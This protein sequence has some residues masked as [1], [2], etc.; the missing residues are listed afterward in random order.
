MSTK[1]SP[2][3]QRFQKNSVEGFMYFGQPAYNAAKDIYK[4]HYSA[5]NS[6]F[7]CSRTPPK[8][9]RHVSILLQN[10]CF[11][12]KNMVWRI[13]WVDYIMRLIYKS[14]L[15]RGHRAHSALC[16]YMFGFLP[17]AAR[18]EAVLGL[19]ILEFSILSF[20]WHFWS[21]DLAFFVSPQYYLVF[22]CCLF[23]HLSV[24]CVRVFYHSQT[25]KENQRMSTKNNGKPIEQGTISM[26]KCRKPMKKCRK[27]MNIEKQTMEHENMK[28][29]N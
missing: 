11:L 27:Q 23:C 5:A 9:Y 2:Y 26:D 8:T 24:I 20:F 14:S 29:I 3:F 12:W 19:R 25:C 15:M 21:F 28:E 17:V 6:L 22:F 16:M 18:Y 4:C 1:I 13:V 10:L 7:F